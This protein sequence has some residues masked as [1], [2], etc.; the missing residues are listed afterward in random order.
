LVRGYP[1]GPKVVVGLIFYIIFPQ[2]LIVDIHPL[3]FHF[4][5]IPRKTNQPLDKGV[6]EVLLLESVGG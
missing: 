3:P 2:G 5:L 4:Y 6:F 1:D